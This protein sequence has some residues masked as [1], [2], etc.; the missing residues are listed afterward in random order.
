MYG[1]DDI[2]VTAEYL[3]MSRIAA[4]LMLGWTF[5]LF[6]AV[7]KPIERRRVLL[8]TV[9]PVMFGLVTSSIVAVT[10]GLV[11]VEYMLPMWLF[12]AIIVIIFLTAYGYTLKVVS[13]SYNISE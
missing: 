4:S 3:Y 7:L 12:N 5:L 1:L 2:T 10:S 8:L 9:I 13:E 6:W 11:R